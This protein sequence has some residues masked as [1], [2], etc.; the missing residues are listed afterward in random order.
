[1]DYYQY[2]VANAQ[3]VIILRRK[4]AMDVIKFRVKFGGLV[5]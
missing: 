4:N 2:V 3:S 5:M 1:M